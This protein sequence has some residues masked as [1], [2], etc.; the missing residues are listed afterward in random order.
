MGSNVQGFFE[1]HFFEHDVEYWF[2]HEEIMLKFPFIKNM[3]EY[4][5]SVDVN[6]KKFLNKRLDVAEITSE[7]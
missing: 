3:K 7:G 5:I 1:K 2:S 4:M 6:G